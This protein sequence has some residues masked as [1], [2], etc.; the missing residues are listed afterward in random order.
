MEP[1]VVRVAWRRGA[2]CPARGVGEPFAGPVRDVER[3][4]RQNEVGTQVGVLVVVER[5]GPLRAKVGLD[6]PN[7]EVHL[8][9]TPRGGVAFLP[10]DGDVVA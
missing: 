5:V 7:G 3:R 10:E 1:C 2:V 9:Q 4:I 6:A 8:R